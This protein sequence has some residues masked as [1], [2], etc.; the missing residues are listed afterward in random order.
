MENGGE[1]TVI[2][3]QRVAGKYH[4]KTGHIVHNPLRQHTVRL[5]AASAVLQ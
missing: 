4:L 3:Q 1:L 2:R 5:F